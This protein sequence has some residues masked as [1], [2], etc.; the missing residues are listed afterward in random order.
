MFD[1]LQFIKHL[2]KNYFDRKYKLNLEI[3]KWF[4][5][6]AKDGRVAKGN[7]SVLNTYSKEKKNRYTSYLH[8]ETVI[9]YYKSLK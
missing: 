7:I 2:E 8:K 9:N 5:E 6:K 3:T 1:Y 4:N